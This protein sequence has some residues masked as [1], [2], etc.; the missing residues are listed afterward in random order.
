MF[1]ATLVMVAGVTLTTL[2]SSLGSGSA[3][4]FPISRFSIRTRR[5]W[6]FMKGTEVEALSGGGSSGSPRGWGS[7]E[8][9][10]GIQIVTVKGPNC[11][12]PL[13][14]KAGSSCVA[15]ELLRAP[16]RWKGWLHLWH[17][18]AE[19]VCLLCGPLMLSCPVLLR[20]P[21]FFFLLCVSKTCRLTAC[22]K[23]SL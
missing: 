13:S 8:N 11:L 2:S 14:F 19:R 15:G 17:L 12:K 20:S 9:D 4:S 21:F 18:R 3:P 10:R 7:R 23:S 16:L 22:Q 5:S 6:H 1:L